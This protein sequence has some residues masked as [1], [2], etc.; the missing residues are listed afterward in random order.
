MLKTK[1]HLKKEKTM[2]KQNDISLLEEVSNNTIV[3]VKSKIIPGKITGNTYN[4]LLFH[5][6]SNY[7]L[8]TAH[9][10]K[11]L[12]ELGYAG[13]VLFHDYNLPT[14]IKI[15]K[16]G[17]LDG[18]LFANFHE[19]E[20]EMWRENIQKF[21]PKQLPLFDWDSICLDASPAFPDYFGKFLQDNFPI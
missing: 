14:G 6:T 16:T 12:T 18:L 20:I 13:T 17:K 2:S 9:Y 15:A 4:F 7:E 10:M 1:I 8:T 11:V 21:Y 19:L 3:G 5:Q